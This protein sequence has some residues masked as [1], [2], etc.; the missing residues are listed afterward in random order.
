MGKLWDTRPTAV[1]RIACMCI[2]TA[3]PPPL[4][5]DFDFEDT[6]LVVTA[7]DAWLVTTPPQALPYP[8]TLDCRFSPKAPLLPL[9]LH[10]SRFSLFFLSSFLRS[11]QVKLVVLS[12]F[13][14]C[15][16]PVPHLH[17]N[18]HAAT[19]YIDAS[20]SYLPPSSQSP[21]HLIDA[22]SHVSYIYEYI[23]HRPQMQQQSPQLQT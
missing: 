3:T 10:C 20:A 2:A 21:R 22:V 9:I 18:V 19:I 5:S 14:F 6:P 11:L 1:R 16:I 8:V 13:K 7:S 17:Q 23:Q 4:P 12:L 15:C